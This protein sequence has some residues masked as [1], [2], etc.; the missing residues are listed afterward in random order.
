MSDGTVASRSDVRKRFN[1]SVRDEEAIAI[2]VM[3]GLQDALVSVGVESAEDYT[4]TQDTF[5]L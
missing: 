2:N 3:G 1:V 4:R 5:S